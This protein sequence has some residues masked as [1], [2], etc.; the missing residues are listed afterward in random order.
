MLLTCGKLVY[1]MFIYPQN[2]YF[3]SFW[4]YTIFQVNLILLYITSY[5]THY[6]FSSY[7]YVVKISEIHAQNLLK[8]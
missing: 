8:F 1:F 5:I 4:I 3:T 2:A 6:Y 7:N